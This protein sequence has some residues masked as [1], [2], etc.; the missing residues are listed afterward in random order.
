VNKQN[1]I[2]Y[3]LV[4]I[5][6]LLSVAATI[7][8]SDMTSATTVGNA[9]LF[10]LVQGGA[11]KK[12]TQA[13]LLTNIF[14]N[15]TAGSNVT[16]TNQGTNII[17]AATSGSSGNTAYAQAITVS[18]TTNRT[19]T[20]AAFTNTFVQAVFTNNLAS[21]NSAVE[22][23]VSG[24]AGGSVV[25]GVL[26]TIFAW[27]GATET[28]IKPAAV[29]ALGGVLI[30]SSASLEPF[31]FTFVHTNITSTTPLTYRLAWNVNSGTANIG[32]RN[33]DTFFD[34]P[35]NITLREKIR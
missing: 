7:K 24:Y 31:S 25:S 11:N 17:I 15:V 34:L 18:D 27:D 14:A 32:R 6:G 9:D 1:I 10:T 23:T 5:L 2:K 28:D 8:I 29:N 4:A 3:G 13:T 19:T 30:N 12:V 22:I 26:F 20:S 21:T 16:V 33:S 35:T